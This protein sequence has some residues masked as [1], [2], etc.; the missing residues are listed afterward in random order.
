MRSNLA[1]IGLPIDIFDAVITG[2]DVER[3]KPFPDCFLQA[4]EAIGLADEVCVVVED[5][6][7]GARA[8]NRSRSNPAWV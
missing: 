4:A 6:E 5:A 8:V 3:K 2:S 1:A 7:N